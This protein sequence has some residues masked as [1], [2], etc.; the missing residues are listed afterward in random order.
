MSGYDRG[1]IAAKCSRPKL[2]D[3]G[4]GQNHYTGLELTMAEREQI[5]LKARSFFD[6]LWTRGDPWELETS[7]WE[8]ERYSRLLAMLDKPRYGR[9]L[10][11]GCGAGTFTR[12]LAGRANKVLALDVS[13]EAIARANLGQSDLKYVE[14]RVGNIMDYN[15]REDKPWDLIVMSET[16]YFLGWLYSFFDVS[17]LA[18]QM[19]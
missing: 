1:S 7:N 2:I 13:S 19:F 12:R 17:W 8:H 5:S 4:C 18:A 11:I 15:F 10:E 16:V 14:F 6:D 3:F 9:V